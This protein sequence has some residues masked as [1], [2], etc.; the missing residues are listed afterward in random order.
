MTDIRRY[1]VPD[2]SFDPKRPLNDLLVAQ[3]EHFQ[4]VERRLPRDL[5]PT[6]RPEMPPPSP[7]DANAAHDYVATMTTLIRRRGGTRS[8]DTTIKPIRKRA[9]STTLPGISIAAGDSQ[10]TSGTS[11]T[12]VKRSGTAVPHKP[13]SSKP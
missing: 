12:N 5:Q 10:T 3:L 4:E 2:D 1:P 11:G 9:S 6:L 8:S 7:R 13:K